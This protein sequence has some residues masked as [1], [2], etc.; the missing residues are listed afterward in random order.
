MNIYTKRVYD[1]AQKSDGTRILVDRLWPRG[2]KKEKAKIKFWAKDV[3]PSNELRK[4][5]NHEPSKWEEF[6]TRYFKELDHNDVAISEL[7]EHC[8]TKVV[9]FIFSS[10]EME[11]N[12]AAALKEYLEINFE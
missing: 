7:L 8:D 6:K 3:A 9:T 2:I 12:N 4:W 5:Y 11:L 1:D 10:K